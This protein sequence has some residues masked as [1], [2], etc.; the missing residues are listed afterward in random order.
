[1]AS[2]AAD[3]F[4]IFIDWQIPS[5]ADRAKASSHK[6]AIESKL[7]QKYGIYRMFQTGSFTHGTGVKNFSDVDC[8][9]SLKSTQPQLSY[10]ILNSVKSTLQ[11]RFP[12]TT[13]RVSRPAVVLEFGGGYETVEI[14]PAYASQSVSDSVMKFQIP[15][16]ATEWLESTPEAHVK[17]VNDC[18]KI[19]SEGKAK[20]FIRLIKAW[21]FYLNVPISSFYLEMRAANYIARQTNV[22]YA[23]D[24]KIFLKELNDIGLADMNDPTGTT[25]RI[26]ACSSDYNKDIALGRLQTATNRAA[27]ALEAHK[28]SNDK[29]AFYY[30][31]QL[32]GGHFPA[33]G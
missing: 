31:D 27:N 7:E 26:R 10:S 9:V 2:S 33:Y 18:N 17:Y 12:F 6:A 14:I 13:I 5:S 24:L 20:S 25:G 29:L 4:R 22:I 15:G 8:F 19:P 28:N 21:K 3:G 11:E 23:Y 32:F 30:W 1:M 16:V